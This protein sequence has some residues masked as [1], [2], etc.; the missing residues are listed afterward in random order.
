MNM[1]KYFILLILPAMLCTSAVHAA[2]AKRMPPGSFLTSPVGSVDQLAQAVKKDETLAAR[3]AKHFGMASSGLSEYFSKNLKLSTLSKP[4]AFT[5][6]YVTR[7]GR[8]KVHK[9]WLRAGTKVFV[10]PKGTPV[11]LVI[12]GNPLVRELIQPVAEV[13]APPAPVQPTPVVSEPA[14]LPVEIAETPIA[15]PIE[16][17]VLSEPPMEVH[18][19][20]PEPMAISSQ[21]AASSSGK[22][23]W[24][25][26]GLVGVGAAVSGGGGGSHHVNVVPE[27]GSLI[28][29]ASGISYLGF[30]FRKRL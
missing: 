9:K 12:C 18:L 6:Y 17:Q 2:K 23:G 3:Y 16:T 4:G 15:E 25:I 28:L 8:I 5:V 10:D 11:I 20:T 27:P 19:L 21:A 1:R 22:S 7:S 13:K 30:I 29:L 26:P 24:F 14:P